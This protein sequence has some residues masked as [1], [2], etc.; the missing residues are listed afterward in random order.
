[1]LLSPYCG[2]LL[3]G[4][5]LTPSVLLL[6]SLLVLA[7]PIQY[8]PNGFE[9]LP[10]GTAMSESETFAKTATLQRSFETPGRP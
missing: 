8:D 7:V 1:M 4:L 6:S 2:L 3:R 9:G 5:I 10:W